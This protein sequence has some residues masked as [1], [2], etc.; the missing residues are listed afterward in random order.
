MAETATPRRRRRKIGDLSSAA[1]QG[2]EL[3]DGLGS[4]EVVRIDQIQVDATYQRSLRHDLINQI[5]REY[6][7][8]KAGPILLSERD[9]GTIWCVDGQHRMAGASLAGEDEIFA[10]VVHGLTRQEEAELRLARNDRRSDSTYE[11]FR[12]RLVMH[13]KKAEAIV[14]LL[15]QQGTQLNLQPNTRVGFNCLTAVE[16]IYDLDGKGVVLGRTIRFLKEAFASEEY[17]G[18]EMTSVSMLLA[19]TWFIDRHIDMREVDWSEM[20]ERVGR[21]GAI[22]LRRKGQNHKAVNGGA[23]WVN[24]YRALVE[25][26]NYGR[27]DTNKIEAKTAGSITNIGDQGTGSDAVRRRN[28]ARNPNS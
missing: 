25:L 4:A 18:G 26:W 11:K 21:A 28:R 2:I 10:H 20:A 15:R 24:V 14:E 27:R 6:D 17:L 7:I 9:D 23:N 13:D 8:V 19:T 12:T 1:T 16:R 22:D 3:N 5:A